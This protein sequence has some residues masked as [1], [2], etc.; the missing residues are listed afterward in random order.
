MFVKSVFA[1]IILFSFSN[2]SQA[3]GDAKKGKARAGTCF[4]CH[5][6]KGV[7]VSPIWPNLAGQKAAYLVKQLKDFKSGARKDASMTAMVAGLS[8]AD[9]E[10]IAAYFSSL[11]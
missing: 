4:A 11:K 10:N 5:G 9:M 7:S 6:A 8:V 3:A 2:F 1:L